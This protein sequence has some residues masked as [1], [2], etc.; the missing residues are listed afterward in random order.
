MVALSAASVSISATGVLLALRGAGVKAASGRLAA[1]FMLFAGIAAI[2]LIV[3]FARGLYV[4][5][6][7][8]TLPML[9]ALPA[10]IFLYVDAR[11]AD[12]CAQAVNWRHGILPVAGLLAAAGYWF[13][14]PPARAAML[15]D[16][17]LP[18]GLIPAALAGATFTLILVW[19]IVS[20]GYLL[21]VLR[22]L[23][24]FRL[25]LKD[26][27]SNTD[28]RELRWIDW[29]MGFLVILWGA[30][31]VTLLGDNFGPGLLFSG[32]FVLALTAALLLFLIAF[33]LVM[34]PPKEAEA[35]TAGDDADGPPAGKYARSAL[36]L[37]IAER[38][39]GRIET[40]MR[41]DKLYLD[42][43]LSL[44]KLSRHVGGAPNLVSQTLNER[45][46]ATFFDYVARW[47]IEAAKSLILA[48]E[49]SVL[50]IAMDV[51]FNS[52]STFY[53][54]FKRETGLTPNA[55]RQAAA[56][57]GQKS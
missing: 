17:A 18:P 43:N 38:L 52:R 28:R 19:S 2:P 41:E 55:F 24:S 32:E 9:L 26:V 12:G 20:L 39:A 56:R 25:R 36:S 30:A 14:P 34:P 27:Y 57:P 53:K 3:T 29:F 35:N 48:D 6:M 33:A 51:G 46:G 10:A 5:Y 23:G 44:Q 13:L 8:A 4:F 11:S 7:P 45:I 49:S 37:D 50:T 21:A 42:A 15:V 16:G 1:V 47:R 40:A 31:A 22:R 54:A